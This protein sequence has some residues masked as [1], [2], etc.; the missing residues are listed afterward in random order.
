MSLA[1]ARLVH[2][3]AGTFTLRT[4]TTAPNLSRGNGQAARW[5]RFALALLAHI[6]LTGETGRYGTCPLS[7]ATFDRWHD[8]DVD[9][10]DPSRGYVA[11]NV[12]LVSARANWGRGMAQENGADIAGWE[13]YA[14]TVRQASPHIAPSAADARALFN[15]YGSRANRNSGQTASLSGSRVEAMLEVQQ[16]VS[17]TY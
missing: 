3:D 8:S 13:R 11:G 1:S 5:G 17:Q 2:L 14:D 4:R 16:Y 12:M 10:L 9:R 7:G 6:A 15:A